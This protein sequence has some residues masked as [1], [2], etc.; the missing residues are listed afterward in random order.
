M[1]R[2]MIRGAGSPQSP[3][4]SPE[5]GAHFHRRTVGV[6]RRRR[7]FAERREMTSRAINLTLM[8]F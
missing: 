4:R 7:G 3:D 1:V 5:F 6:D 2:S 8:A